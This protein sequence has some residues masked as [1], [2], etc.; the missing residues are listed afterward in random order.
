MVILGR[1]QINLCEVI[2]SRHCGGFLF[3]FILFLCL[4]ADSHE[5]DEGAN[6][7]GKQLPR[8]AMEEAEIFLSV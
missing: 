6:T 2:K 3:H 1:S 7:E 4:F 5:S 8:P